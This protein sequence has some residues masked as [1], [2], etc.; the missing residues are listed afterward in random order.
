MDY[1]TAGEI[2]KD[3]KDLMELF[4]LLQSMPE[5]SELKNKLT[6]CAGALA[7]INIIFGSCWSDIT[8]PEPS[9][10]EKPKV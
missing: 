6:E 8:M 9:E 5:N 3:L 2:D 7:Q 4:M 10:N 1:E